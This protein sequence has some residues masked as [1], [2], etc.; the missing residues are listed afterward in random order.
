MRDGFCQT[1]RDIATENDQFS[2]H[3]HAVFSF[4]EGAEHK[5][6]AGDS[7]DGDRSMQSPNACYLFRRN[8]G[9]NQALKRQRRDDG[10]DRKT[11]K[12]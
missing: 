9:V 3:T 11:M 7:G 10:A 12:K 8:G 5:M 1:S 2:H 4:K 6:A